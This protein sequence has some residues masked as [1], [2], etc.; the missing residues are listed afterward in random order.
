MLSKFAEYLALE[1]SYDIRVVGYIAGASVF[2]FALFA[3]YVYDQL[4]TVRPLLVFVQVAGESPPIC[5]F[6][7]LFGR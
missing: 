3:G 5:G 2:A 6:C 4:A 1:F 7:V